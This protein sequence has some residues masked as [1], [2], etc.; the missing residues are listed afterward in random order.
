MRI[1]VELVAAGSVGH[2]TAHLG[3]PFVQRL[4]VA[5]PDAAE[6]V[7]EPRVEVVLRD[8]LGEQLTLPFLAR[9]PQLA[10]GQAWVLDAPEIRL[11]AAA[12][13]RVDTQTGADLLVT[14]HARGVR[15]VVHH[16]PVT[17]LASRQWL[18]DPEAPL[19]SL[20][21]LAAFVQPH[22]PCVLQ[23]VGSV[24]DELLRA[25][26]KASLAIGDVPAERID[27]IVAATFTAV[28][29]RDI[30]YAEPPPSWG[31]G[32]LVRTPDD[33]LTGR[34]GTC[35]DTTLTLAAILEHL[36]I[37]TQLW[38]VPGH[39]FLG[40][41][42]GSGLALP[43]AVSLQ[44]ASAVNAVDLGAV[45]LV[46][47]TFLTRER[48]PPS[49][50]VRRAR[51][52]PVDAWIRTGS[53]RILGVV[54]IGTARL[55]GLLPLPARR[56]RDDGVI[57]VVEY[58]AAPPAAGRVG[59]ATAPAADTAT[60]V[61]GRPAAPAPI[62]RSAGAGIGE[63]PHPARAVPATPA[64]VQQWKNALL[65]LTLRNPLLSMTSRLTQLPL[66]VPHGELG[67]VTDLLQTGRSITLREPGDLAWAASALL[68]GSSRTA[69]PGDIARNLLAQ[70]ST[71]FSDVQP[72]EHHPRIDR[73]RYRARTGVQET[74]ANLLMLTVGR[75]DWHL[76]ERRLA[77]PVLLMPAR[78]K[79][80]MPPY[81]VEADPAGQLTVNL[82]LLEKL[83]QEFG[84]TVP[85][86]ADLP[87]RAD[88]DGVDVAAALRLLREAIAD[89]G[90]PF[91]VDDE[92][93]LA[94]LAYTGYLLWRDL[95]DHWERFL[96]APLLRHLALTPT[97]AMAEPTAEPGTVQ[98]PGKG[99]PGA[100]DLDEITA[101]SPL[102]LDASQAAAV[103]AAR[104]GRSFVLEGPP[105]TGKSQTI[106]AI[107]ADQLARGASVL[108]V[109]EKGAALDVV[110][111]RLTEI[112]LDELTLDLHDDQ[113]RP[114][115]VRAQLKRALDL[116][117]RPDRQA[118]TSVAGDLA[119]SGAALAD[120]AGRVHQPNPAGLSLYAARS[121]QLI[122]GGGPTLSVPPDVPGAR[123][124]VAAAVP[125]LLRLTENDRLA[126]GFAGVAAAPDSLAPLLGRADAAVEALELPA[127]ASSALA[128]C[129]VLD[130]LRTVATLLAFDADPPTLAEVGSRR[131]QEAAAELEHRLGAL[132]RRYEDEL[133]VFEPTVT[134]MDLGEL[135]AVRQRVREARASFVLGRR[136]RLLAAAAPVLVHL[137][138]GAQL[139]PRDLPQLTERV[140]AVAREARSIAAAWRALPGCAVLPQDVQPLTDEGARV[141]GHRL[142]ALRTSAA[143][144]TRLPDR[145]AAAVV[146]A[147]RAD[148]PL[149]PAGRTQ[150]EAVAD[151]LA[152]VCAALQ[153]RE[154]DLRHWSAGTAGGLVGTWA[155]T[156]TR[157]REDP[158]GA[159]LR[160]W[161]EAAE[162]LRPLTGLAE[163]ARRQLLD[164]EVPPEGA[165]AAL[166]RGLAAASVTERRDHH[167]F[168]GFD[169]RRHDAVLDQ[170]CESAD[171]LRQCLREVLPATVVDRRPFAPR[172]RT[173]ATGV[174]D[175]VG[176]AIG[177]VGAL[178]REVN[179]TR[180]GLS[181]RRL[182]QQFGPVIA[183]VTPC[184]LVSPDSLARFVPPE[185]MTFDLVV[186][187]E[188]SQITVADAVGALGRARAAVIAG[189]SRQ[190][191]PSRFG[192]AA[193]EEEQAVTPSQAEGQSAAVL[194]D[195]GVV[196]D[197][198]S[199]LSEA[200]AAGV[201]RLW[202]SWHYRSRDESLIAFSN[203]HYYDDRLL[204]FPAVPGRGQDSGISLTRVPGRFVRSGSDPTG[205]LRTN[206]V[207]ATAVVEEVVRRWRAGQRSIGVVTFNVQQRGLIESMLRESGEAE[208][209]LALEN[210]QEGVFVKNLEN[211]QGDERDVVL[212][213]TGFSA[214]ARGVLPLNFGPLNRLGGERRLNVAVTRARRR[215]MVFSSF[216]P[217]DLRA[218]QTSS[219]G[220]KHLRAY[221]ELA[222]AGSAPPPRAEATVDRHRD[223]V[224][225]RL[226]AAGLGVSTALGTSEFQVDLAITSSAAPAGS[227]PSLAVLLDGES[228]AAR[229]TTADRDALPVT[230][231]R[232]VLG[233][234]DV[235][236]IWLPDWLQDP[237][238]V[239]ARVLER[240]EQARTGVQRHGERR[241]SAISLSAP[242]LLAPDPA[243]GSLTQERSLVVD[244]LVREDSLRP[245]DPLVVEE[246]PAPDG[247]GDPEHA[248]T[249][250]GDHSRADPVGWH[251]A[252]EDRAEPFRAFVPHLVGTVNRLDCLNQHRLTGHLEDLV[253]E[254]VAVE[255]PLSALRLTRHVLACHGVSRVQP[256]RVT[257]LVKALPAE[258]RRDEEGFIW[259]AGRDPS[260]WR[261]YRPVA[262]QEKRPVEEI[263]LTE[264]G[265]ALVD[266][267]RRAMGIAEEDLFRQVVRV[268]GGLRV[269]DAVRRRL[270]DALSR[271]ERAGRVE[272]AGGLVR[273]GRGDR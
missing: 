178:E 147:R 95:D 238:R 91:R 154:S 243:E 258:L 200:V 263:A 86:L 138:P 84:F 132:R 270:G 206:P 137:R 1:D 26:K 184:L 175:S 157:R 112:G 67:T 33:V 234:P 127:P 179:R 36:G 241:R 144:L 25:T 221:L 237:D 180:R 113:A 125:A 262:P 103:A 92:A 105:G 17:V 116:R 224:A 98:A 120:Y 272:R 265:N 2:A 212:F 229:R 8:A 83:R 140:T 246:G 124:A 188:A 73:L 46:E 75:L 44:A 149:A 30:S 27:A 48:R 165:V 235:M 59:S 255:G 244:P 111:A 101:A 256:Q 110:R 58:R 264:L 170:F 117:P 162:A 79:G 70:R 225:G 271:A 191:P 41:W 183:E 122:R 251:G 97:E 35:L 201:P 148:P 146:A 130:E 182:L 223:D 77:A 107:L 88:G 259:P 247:S 194:S 176:S 123:E 11:D 193:A 266:L 23:I 65:D 133:A 231:L 38:V 222:A 13:S 240:A 60:D 42:R 166:E 61:A 14:V 115:E 94:I 109:A 40:Y 207:E 199:I 10:P 168:G 208:L 250:T 64:R 55:T 29:R 63:A 43:E 204:T 230:V 102:P 197:E 39:A 68:A 171:A 267:S 269:T 134:A 22:H 129:E 31:Y 4:A 72:G 37:G 12:L 106:A 136:R 135:D 248:G 213:S 143:A 220:I 15:P 192:T 57:E 47:T 56:A 151:A 172:N 69:L 164:A 142:A 253:R 100:P 81:K 211:V 45:G 150:V 51:Q 121:L 126:W 139:A 90:L 227:P 273:V 119:A 242:D 141:I 114:S 93:R 226:R 159:G 50:L 6:P 181:V 198:E 128:S 78:I 260:T 173:G 215:V 80:V 189:D 5:F 257:D 167:G 187:D 161:A 169:A 268:F 76:G 99:G 209:L 196:P 155:R 145:P 217:S 89:S 85:G 18:L 202:L 62:A 236:R 195:Y 21:H 28:H 239:I 214:D 203:R 71:L 177:A 118:Y 210:R 82:S 186:F 96:E 252:A 104:A 190:L 108:F 254:I 49:D 19:R 218:D 249:R 163:A 24:G 54:D 52:A 16:Q 74:G 87:P 160:R 156:A 9:R 228:W 131:W 174:I 185:A 205:A 53:A 153:V 232:E 216:D 152:P 32:Q 261:G 34:V 245:E 3:T 233:W 66:S 158:A 219:V 20:E 7:E